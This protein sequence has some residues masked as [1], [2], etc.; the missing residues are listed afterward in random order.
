MNQNKSQ[1]LR[2]FRDFLPIEASKRQWLRNK[3]SQIFEKWGYEPLETP[4]LEPLEIFENQIGEGENMFFK[5]EDNGGRKVALRYDQSVPTARVV[6]RFANE[7]AFPFKRYQIQSA[8]RAEKP[9]KGRYREFVQC[10][11]DIFG[12]K[13]ISADA[14]VIAL[15]IS[16]YKELGFPQAKVFVSD[17]DLLKNLPYEAIIAIDKL[18]KIGE[19]SVI[20]EMVKK[21]IDKNEAVKYLNQATNLKPNNNIEYILKYLKDSNIDENW[22]SF[23]PTLA[24]SF[25]YSNGPIWEVKIPGFVSGSVLGGER[26][27]S[28]AKKISGLDIAATGFGLGFDRTIE[29]MEQFSLLPNSKTNTKV[30]VTVFSP[31]TQ[32]ESIKLAN[33]LR[34]SNINT[35]LYPTP[36]KLSKQFKYASDKNIPYVAVLGPDELKNNTI[37]LKNMITGEQ[38]QLNLSS[39]LVQLS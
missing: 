26:F 37:T 38:K 22:F 33:E 19:K 35:L 23:E 1:P 30:L 31:D 9:Q 20:E 28:V 24:R 25:S 27:D 6:A 5:F 18:E 32:T 7:I 29:A 13:D 2:G 14:E 16:I 10:D 17:R 11:A 39:L 4:T 12:V 21:G 15:A 34:Q 3:L 8:F 36:E